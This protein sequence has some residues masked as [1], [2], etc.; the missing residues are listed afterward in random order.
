MAAY[1]AGGSWM[2]WVLI[3]LVIGVVVYGLVWYFFL[4]GN[5]GSGYGNNNSSGSTQNT[6]YKY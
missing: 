1:G 4:G 3:Y 6:P 5:K 2:K